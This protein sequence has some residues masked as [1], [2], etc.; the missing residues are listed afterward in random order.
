MTLRS[1]GARRC[2]AAIGAASLLS[3]VA[4]AISLP[5]HHLWFLAP[6]G[7]AAQAAIVARRPARWRFAAGLLAGVG[8]FAIA[9]IWAFQFTGWGYLVL[10]LFESVLFG[11]ACLL[12]APTRGRLLGYAASMTLL[13][14]VRDSFPFGGVPL[15]GVALSQADGPLLGVARIGG[16]YLVVAA[17]AL[18][19]SGL[20]G[21]G[22]G[23][24]SALRG[25]FN[26][27]AVVG[28][29]GAIV[30]VVIAA[31][32]TGLAPNGGSPI[33]RELVDIVQGGGRRGVTALEVSPTRA[34]PAT[35]AVLERI[36]NA[37]RLVVTPENALALLG[38]PTGSPRAKRFAAI[39]ERLRATLLAGV[40]WPVGRTRFRNELVAFGPDGALV[41]SIEKV[42]PVPFG[43]YVPF[44]S[45]IAKIVNLDAV[46][47]DVIVGRSDSTATTPAG[48]LVLLNSFETFF[49]K[50]GRRGVNFG[51]QLLVVE[52][53]TASYGTSQVP[54]VELAASRIQAVAEGRTLVQSATTGYSAVVS[55]AGSV[56]HQGP[57]GRPDLIAATVALRGGRTWYDDAG[58]LPFAVAAVI[59]LVLSW[60]LD[61][62]AARAAIALF[63]RVRPR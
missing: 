25:R 24:W 33:R 5:P 43:E 23:A 20:A 49:P 29:V 46:P 18:A 52:T 45:L 6:L 53:N 8:Q 58:D 39:A 59:L 61:P 12:V 4:I 21:I 57:L 1:P 28:G 27:A 56:T 10:V 15:G 47:R 7:F 3:G 50:I 16:P 22:L 30:L 41:A 17:V 40:T 60:S 36:R 2:A 35:L 44:R 32:I 34:Y 51:G 55:P 26:A 13:E 31:S 38:P 62:R 19:G 37:P 11:I 54:A 9:S 14:A 48:R 63:R 42:H